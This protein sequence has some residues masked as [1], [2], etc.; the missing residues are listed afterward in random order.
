[1]GTPAPVLCFLLLVEVRGLYFLVPY[2]VDHPAC[3]RDGRFLRQ[4]RIKLA[5]T[6]R[7]EVVAAV[8]VEVHPVLH[9]GLLAQV[10][11]NVSRHRVGVLIPEEATGVGHREAADR[12]PTR[13]AGVALGGQGH[14]DGPVGG[15]SLN[16]GDEVVA[17]REGQGWALDYCPLEA[18][19]VLGVGQ[20]GGYVGGVDPSI[21]EHLLGL[22]HKNEIAGFLGLKLLTCDSAPCL[23]MS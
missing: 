7:L 18:V 15:Q 1:M 22:L 2:R 9:Y 23:G 21:S 6:G 14:L 5:P 12:Q 11:V 17:P 16:G 4:R 20:I 3:G 10:A 19:D 8:V 13:R